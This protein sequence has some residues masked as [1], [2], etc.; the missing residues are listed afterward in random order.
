MP[1]KKSKSAKAKKPASKLKKKA[2]ARK[3]REVKKK[4]QAKKKA[5][6][7]V[8]SRSKPATPS[9]KPATY[10]PSANEIKIG[11]VEDYFSHIGV[12]ALT[13]KDSLSIGDTIHVRGHTTDLTQD[14][15]SMQI[16]RVAVEQAKNEDSVGIKIS[17]KCRKGDDVY[18]VS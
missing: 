2:S 16:N 18:R 14:V 3:V 8:R 4:T 1:K 15:D 17:Q 5:A 10:Q 7:A 11:E 9:S 13:L 12:I 6:R